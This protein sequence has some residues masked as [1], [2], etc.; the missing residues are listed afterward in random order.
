MTVSWYV[1]LNVIKES[2][3]TLKFKNKSQCTIIIYDPLLVYPHTDKTISRVVTR[4]VLSSPSP[5]A[6][7]PLGPLMSLWDRRTNGVKTIIPTVHS[8]YV[9]NKSIKAPP[10]ILHWG[11]LDCIV[12]GLTV[13]HI[14]AQNGMTYGAHWLYWTWMQ[15]VIYHRDNTPGWAAVLISGP[16]IT[17]K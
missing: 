15:M 10:A 2:T 7:L 8:D 11:L 9:Q 14:R 12:I 6:L 5:R 13:E 4:P 16:M 17:C 1:N 3:C